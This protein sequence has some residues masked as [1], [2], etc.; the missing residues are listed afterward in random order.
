M[1]R[2]ILVA[3]FVAL[4][5]C[6][7]VSVD[8][9]TVFAPVPFDA[10]LA[11]ASGETIEGE[12]NYADGRA[13]EAAW[14]VRVANGQLTAPVPAFA[15][16]KVHH[17]KL[18]N[19]VA[20]S[21]VSRADVSRPLI[22]RCGGNATTRQQDGF[23]YS[24]NAIH[25]GDVFL[26][27]YVGSGETGGEVNTE[28]FLAMH[29]GLVTAIRERAAGRDLI[30]WGH[31]LGGFVCADLAKSLPETRGVILEAT[32]RNASEV[33]KAWTPWYAGPFVQITIEPSMQAY[34]TADLL[35]GFK[36]PVLVLGAGQDKTLPVQL[37]RSLGKAL[38][39]QGADSTY[40]EFKDGGHSNLP[41]QGG[42][43]KAVDDFFSRIHAAS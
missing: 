24:A 25:H 11:A 26:F 13:W 3:A 5:A 18:P 21:M 6:T 19:G 16:T 42:Y 38:K 34:D 9:S 30:F 29:D 41:G 2:T 15:P 10:K 27:D 23:F 43:S 31:S 22:V 17:G 20:W 37:A 7:K 35:K 33:A 14:N 40:I 8:E 36:G 1:K 39:E 4:A 28:K 12:R 32:A